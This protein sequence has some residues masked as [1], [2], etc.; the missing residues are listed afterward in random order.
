MN[1]EKTISIQISAQSVT[2]RCIITDNSTV[3]V[4]ITLRGWHMLYFEA[5]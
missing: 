5:K 1:A 3:D 2:K 4:V